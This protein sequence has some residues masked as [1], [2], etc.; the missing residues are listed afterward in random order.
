MVK[1]NKH[2]TKINKKFKNATTS[3]KNNKAQQRPAPS[4]STTAFT[5]GTI[6]LGGD[7]G[8]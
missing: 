2:N 7:G 5:F 1:A 8:Q 3:R 4:E 6:R